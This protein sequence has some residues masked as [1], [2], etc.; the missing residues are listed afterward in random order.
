[1]PE[2][3]IKNKVTD[4][5]AFSNKAMISVILFPHKKKSFLKEYALDFVGTKME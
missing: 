1:M 3:Y 2:F 4:N 5:I